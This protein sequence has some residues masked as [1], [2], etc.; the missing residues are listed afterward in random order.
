VRKVPLSSILFSVFNRIPFSCKKDAIIPGNG[1]YE[2]GNMQQKRAVIGS[3]YSE[4]SMFDGFL[5]RTARV[6]E[7]VRLI[8]NLGEAFRGNKKDKCARILLCPVK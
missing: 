8:F 7:V 4:N 2:K 1:I 5:V 6:N 3:M